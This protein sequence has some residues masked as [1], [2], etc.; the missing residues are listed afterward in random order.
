MVR[1]IRINYYGNSATD[2]S[3]IYVWLDL[4]RRLTIAPSYHKLSLFDFST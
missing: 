2:E 1:G 3:E 4:V